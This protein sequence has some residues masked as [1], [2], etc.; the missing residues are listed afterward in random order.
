MPGIWTAKGEYIEFDEGGDSLTT[1]LAT[2][3]SVGLDL[4]GFLNWLPDPDPVLNKRGEAADVLEEL[5]ADDKVVTCT[6]IRK[7]QTLGKQNYR[8][9]VGCAD[10]QEPTAEAKRICDQL[11]ADLENVD[12]YGL[13]SAILD[14]PFFGFTP[15]ELIWETR[16]GRLRLA[17]AVAKPRE[18]F[19]WNGENRLVFNPVSSSQVVPEHKFVV[20]RHFPT[21]KNPYGLRLLSRCLWPVAFKRGG[22]QFWLTFA[23]RFGMPWVV[24]KAPDKFSREQR[25][26]MA[27]D[28]AAMVQD[29]VA[30]LASGS[31]VDMLS[32]NSKGGVHPEL[33]QSMNGAISQVLMGQTLTA[34]IGKNGSYAASKTHLN[35]LES[36]ADAD[37]LLVVSTMN[38]LAWTY[39]RVNAPEG[40][41][42]PVFE[43]VQQ[44]D[45]SS[46]ADL[47]KKLKELGARFRK[48]YFVRV[49]GLAED[50]FDVA[51][52]AQEPGAP[53][54]GS[55]ASS[56]ASFAEPPARSAQDDIDGAIADILPDAVAANT[57]LTSAILDAVNRAETPEDA[58]LLLA[59]LLGSEAETAE[60]EEL[61]ARIMV[62]AELRGR[63]AVKGGEDD[64]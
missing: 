13:R 42:A 52:P 4:G 36:F 27:A 16:G 21:F 3:A 62:N 30:V 5:L 38:E 29:A 31:E 10:G 39:T 57:A 35:V 60:L 48:G 46:R 37:E 32:S 43:F 33:V 59:E 6:Q 54:S 51:D 40:T 50:E 34:E 11:N 63:A 12:L 56:T 17:D 53:F 15:I 55:T 44:E 2:R 28:L 8:F 1:E 20:A 25:Q 18:W 45:L 61:L 24:A 7:L 49:Y 41:L 58:M 22:L 47:D 14:A 23:E 19:G 9:R 26:G 64:G